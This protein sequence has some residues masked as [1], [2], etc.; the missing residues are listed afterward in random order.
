[1]STCGR[2]KA[3]VVIWLPSAACGGHLDRSYQQRLPRIRQ[4]LHGSASSVG[5]LW[6]APGDGGLVLESLVASEDFTEA[7]VVVQTPPVIGG[8]TSEVK[9]IL[10]PE[11]GE[12]MAEIVR[13][14]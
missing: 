2:D 10:L 11:L 7:E 4:V 3:R 14:G 8:D 12:P 5:E 1:M 6:V 13:V 9:P